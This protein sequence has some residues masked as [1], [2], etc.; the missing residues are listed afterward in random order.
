MAN[1]NENRFAV[2]VIAAAAALSG[3]LFGYGTGVISGAL[4]YI[5][6]DFSLSG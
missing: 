6:D 2:V 1:G 5:Q 3:V 4:I